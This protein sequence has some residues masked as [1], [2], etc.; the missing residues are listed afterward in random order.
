MQYGFIDLRLPVLEHLRLVIDNDA[1]VSFL[2]E[3]DVVAH[4]LIGGDDN[5]SR[6]HGFPEL[7]PH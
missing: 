1:V 5:V 7:L 3:V 4:C 6:V 2:K